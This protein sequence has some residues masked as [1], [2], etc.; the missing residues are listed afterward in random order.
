MKKMFLMAIAILSLLSFVSETAYSMTEEMVIPGRFEKWTTDA[1][2]GRYAE[3][4][5]AYPYEICV[6][7]ADGPTTNNDHTFAFTSPGNS[8]VGEG[9]TYV[10]ITDID[11]PTE[12]ENGGIGF[13]KSENS[14][15]YTSYSAWQ[16]ALP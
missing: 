15:Y 2:G 6:S 14:V 9:W 12:F 8:S 16:A 10:E 11:E 4:D 3:C 5:R 1:N 7:Y 13:T